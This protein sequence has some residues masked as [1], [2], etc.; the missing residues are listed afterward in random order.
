VGIAE[1]PG[2]TIVFESGAGVT[3]NRLKKHPWREPH[4]RGLQADIPSKP[5]LSHILAGGG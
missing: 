2:R 3:G 5:T 4:R 1:E